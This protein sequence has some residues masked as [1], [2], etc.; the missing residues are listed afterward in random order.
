M[1][2]RNISFAGQSAKSFGLKIDGVNPYSA[3]GNNLEPVK[4]PGRPGLD[5][6]ADAPL[7]MENEILEFQAGLYLPQNTTDSAVAKKMAEIR[8]WLLNTRQGPTPQQGYRTLRTDYEPDFY[9]RAFFSGDFVPQRKG[10]GQD[11]QIP[12]N[13]S[14]DPRRYLYG[15]PD[16]VLLAG[17]D[18]ALTASIA[19]PENWDALVVKPAKPLIKIEGNLQNQAF[20]LI[21]TDSDYT[22][23]LGKISVAANVGTFWFDCETLN[24]TSQE[25]GGANRNQY[26]TEVSGDVTL[27]GL[28][29]YVMRTNAD[30]KI[31]IRPRWWV[32]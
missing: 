22:E 15:A 17:Q 11:F 2:F 25:D 6:A 32:R 23:E 9:R 28:I 21:F 20:S 31:T 26:I 3:S 27:S 4:V 10:A 5:V 16:T 24:A 18:G 7:D 8:D 30:A 13:F 19:P 29:S 12:L 1:S 14:C